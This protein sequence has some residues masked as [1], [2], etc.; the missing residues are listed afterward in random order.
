EPRLE[1]PSI[2]SDTR[3]VDAVAELADIRDRLD[4]VLASIGGQSSR[5]VVVDLDHPAD[6]AL[7][8]VFNASLRDW[9]DDLRHPVQ[10][11]PEHPNRA[12]FPRWAEAADR[13]HERIDEAL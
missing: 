12:D 5:R 11:E 9:A 4:A 10:D 13:L 8:S 1:D 3:G 7:H 2:G 6:P